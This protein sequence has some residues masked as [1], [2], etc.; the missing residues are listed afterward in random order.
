M[1]LFNVSIVSLAAFDAGTPKGPAAAPERKVTMPMRYFPLS[2]ATA[3]ADIPVI[4]VIA[5]AL[6]ARRKVWL[7]KC[8]MD[9]M[10][11]S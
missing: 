4:K 10:D 1:P 11:V 8:G 9:F 7:G 6:A 2:A 5:A 3:E